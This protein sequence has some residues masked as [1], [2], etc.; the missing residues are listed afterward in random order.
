MA[1]DRRRGPEGHRRAHRRTAGRVR[2]RR[3]RRAGTGRGAGPADRRPVRRRDR[4]DP[5]HP[6]RRGPARRGGALRP[7]R[8]R[9]GGQPA[10]RPR[11][12][13]LRRGR[14]RRAGA[15]GVRPYLGSHGGDVELLE[16]TDGGRRT[17][18][19]AGQL[20]RLRVLLGHPHP[21][22]RGRDRGGGPRGG[23]H[24]GGGA[25][26][27]GR[28][29]GGHPGLGAPL[30]ARRRR[31]P[32]APGSRCPAST[33]SPPARSSTV[34]VGDLTLLVARLGDELFA[35]VDRCARC[36][37]SLAGAVLSRRIGAAV[38]EAVLRCP[39]C[40]AHYDVRRA[41]R[42]LDDD[43]RHLDPV[44]LLTDHG[45]TSVAVPASPVSA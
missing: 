21:R 11:A 42:C 20:R 44:P 40:R 14:A 4:A 38:G 8:G 23:R 18:A 17:A 43:A 33:G 25:G 27:G 9:P 5:G 1:G 34:A 30:P 37:S 19:A 26:P 3:R 29:A 13:P 39:R 28:P 35:Y 12:A 41:G 24:R 16:V 7:R 15:G 22:G 45:V 2:V 10:A 31:R 32:P 36:E 6:L